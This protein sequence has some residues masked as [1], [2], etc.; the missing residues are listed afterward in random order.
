MAYFYIYEWALRSV[1]AEEY[2]F[3]LGEYYAVIIM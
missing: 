3:K 1:R 2:E